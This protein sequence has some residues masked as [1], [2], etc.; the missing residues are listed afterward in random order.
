LKLFPGLNIPVRQDTV[1]SA[2][3]S[4]NYQPIR[5]VNLSTAIQTERLSSNQAA[6]AYA[7]KTISL[8]MSFRF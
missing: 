1:N 7:D 6:I 4:L 5:N 8:S 2:G 3:I